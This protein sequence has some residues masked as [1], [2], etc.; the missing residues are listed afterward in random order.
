MTDGRNQ[1]DRAALRGSPAADDGGP[2]PWA[3]AL[4]AVSLGAIAVLVALDIATDARAG[5]GRGH[6]VVEAVVVA[7]AIAGA[8]VLFAQLASARRRAERDLDRARADLVRFR[9]ESEHL[10]RGLG[11]AI[12]RQ[13]EGWGLSP[14]EREVG[15]LLLKGLSLKDIAGV[16]ATSERTV[17]QQA[18]AIYRKAGLSGRAELAAFFLEDLLLPPAPVARLPGQG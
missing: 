9:A 6:L 11:A 15:L 8:A 4:P 2:R 1:S 10:L 13:F 14:A 5:S 3:L 17:R 7:V 18:L 16:R 12:D